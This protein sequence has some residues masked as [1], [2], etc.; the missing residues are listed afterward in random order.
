MPQVRKPIQLPLCQMNPSGEHSNI[1]SKLEEIFAYRFKPLS[2]IRF[3]RTFD[4]RDEVRFTINHLSVMDMKNLV[5]AFETVWVDAPFF[6]SRVSV[7]V[8]SLKN[9]S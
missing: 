4:R 8:C 1:L 3:Q 5:E 2:G 6:G 7:R 9:R